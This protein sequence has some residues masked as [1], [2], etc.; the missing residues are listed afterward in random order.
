MLIDFGLAGPLGAASNGGTPWYVAPEYLEEDVRGT[1]ADVFALGVVMLY[2]LRC[3]V[4][5]ESW[6]RFYN[7]H[8]EWL[9]RDIGAGQLTAVNAMKNW[10]QEVDRQ[11]DGLKASDTFSGSE[12]ELRMLVYRMLLP[13]RKRIT[14]MD[15]VCAISKWD[16]NTK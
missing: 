7:E 10:L 8:A 15:L 9:I 16:L 3:C 2:V 6:Y 11:R 12:A 5:P 14:S 1:P 13:L 4:L